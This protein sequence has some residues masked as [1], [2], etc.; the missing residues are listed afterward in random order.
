MLFYYHLYLQCFEGHP[1]CKK[2]GC[3]FVGDD[4]T[5]AL[6]ILQLQLSPPPPSSITPI[7]LA[8]SGSLGK[9]S[10]TME[11]ERERDTLTLLLGSIRPL[12]NPGFSNSWEDLLGDQA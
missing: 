11:R 9:M 1:A 10:V 4:L 3:C 6:H 2:V 8:N 7:K 12:K 5:G